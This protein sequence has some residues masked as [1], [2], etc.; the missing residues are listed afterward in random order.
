MSS[1]NFGLEPLIQLQNAS[2]D[3]VNIHDTLIN[4]RLFGFIL[5]RFSEFALVGSG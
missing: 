1:A 2:Q 4:P 5:L 3:A